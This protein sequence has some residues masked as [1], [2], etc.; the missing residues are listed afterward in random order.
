MVLKSNQTRLLAVVT[1][2]TLTAPRL[3]EYGELVSP[4]SELLPI[5]ISNESCS[6]EVALA[7]VCPA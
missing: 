3:T 6:V 1:D 4:G 2:P 7:S 5:S